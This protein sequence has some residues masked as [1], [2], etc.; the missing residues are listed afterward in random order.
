MPRIGPSPR[1]AMG[2]EDVSQFQ[3]WPGHAAP[4]SVR[5]DGSEHPVLDKLHLLEGADSALDRLGGDM[6]IT[7]R[8]AELGMTQ[9]HLDRRTCLHQIGSGMRSKLDRV[10]HGAAIEVGDKGKDIFGRL[11]FS[12]PLRRQAIKGQ[13]KSGFHTRAENRLFATIPALRVSGPVRKPYTSDLST[14]RACRAARQLQRRDPNP[15][16]W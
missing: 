13:L 14:V 9:Q 12:G 6:G 1:R 10:G 2:A 5:P 3:R 7:R 16:R 11:G 8:G 15:L 4:A